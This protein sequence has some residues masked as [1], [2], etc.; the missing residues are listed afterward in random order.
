MSTST[1][2]QK[3]LN[4]AATTSPTSSLS[5]IQDQEAEDDNPTPAAVETPRPQSAPTSPI[6]QRSSSDELV[7]QDEDIL[8]DDDDIMMAGDEEDCAPSTAPKTAAERRA[9]K[10]KMKR[11]RLTHN[12]TRFLMSE[13][14]RQA[15]PD[16]AQRERLSREIPGLTPRQVQVWFQNRR[17]KLK[18]LTTEDR[19]RM[20]KSRALPEDFDMAQTLHTQ[21]GPLPASFSTPMASPVSYPTSFGDNG[22]IRPLMIDGMRR[23]SEDESAMSPISM[24]S[25]YSSFYTPPAS[26]AAS[27]TMSPLSPAPERS[28]FANIHLPQGT[29]QPTSRRPSP[30]IRS[31]SFT[32]GFHANPHVPRLQTHDRV[33][34]TRAESLA[35]PLRTSMSYNGNSFDFG[36]GHDAGSPS[37]SQ[38]SP[39]EPPKGSALDIS[40]YT[41]SMSNGLGQG[42]SSSLLGRSK[43]PKTTF[44]PGLDLRP[45]F[46]PLVPLSAFP[47]LHSSSPLHAGLQSAP[48]TTPHDF[49]L[50]VSAAAA[51]NARESLSYT[52]TVTST[53][54][55]PFPDLS[56]PFG[57][58]GS[59]M[60]GRIIEEVA[61]DGYAAASNRMHMGQHGSGDCAVDDG[62]SDASSLHPLFSDNAGR[63]RSF[64]MP[65]GFAVSQG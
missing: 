48:L 31:T 54:E 8:D 3:S 45:Q 49:H 34:R 7:D 15:H 23:N 35:S 55:L 44:T 46:R 53:Y 60:H 65:N 57:T 25:A 13:F 10:R 6:P 38:Y 33:T 28:N 22:M 16:A 1:R 52:A 9:E 11:F 63:R 12:Q 58:P 56:E 39:W 18:R 36:A 29:N 5:T 64:T 26:I 32:T 40:S 19:E 30:F 50:P 2:H 62:D 20:M 42:F 24:N 17:A 21:F 51:T 27:D 4:P 37:L 59:S 61:E 43:P 14:A 47:H 41:A